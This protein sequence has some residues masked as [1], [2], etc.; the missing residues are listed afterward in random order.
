M[1]FRVCCAYFSVS[2]PR[3][4]AFNLTPSR[5]CCEHPF[6]LLCCW[7]SPI[8][9]RCRAF[10]PEHTSD[11]AG[12]RVC[13]NNSTHVSWQNNQGTTRRAAE[14]REHAMQSERK[15]EKVRFQREAAALQSRLLGTMRRLVYV[16]DELNTKNGVLKERDAYIR[17]LE[18]QLVQTH[19]RPGKS[20]SCGGGVAEP[21][22]RRRT[23][24]T[25]QQCDLSASL[26]ERGRAA[27]V[28]ASCASSLPRNDLR[29][30]A[31][32]L[33]LAGVLD[34][35]DTGAAATPAAAVARRRSSSPETPAP[36]HPAPADSPCMEV[37]APSVDATPSCV[38]RSP[39]WRGPGV[40][41]QRHTAP[42]QPVSKRAASAVRRGGPAGQQT[43]LQRLAGR[44]HT[45]TAPARRAPAVVR[46]EQLPWAEQRASVGYADLQRAARKSGATLARDCLESD[47][48]AEVLGTPAWAA[49][50]ASDC[51]TGHAVRDGVADQ[52][53][54]AMPPVGR[55][56][57]FVVAPLVSGGLQTSL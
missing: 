20:Q 16:A 53:A 2:L 43:P 55:C 14:S 25:G 52:P 1:L 42:R 12:Q 22:P 45:S 40:T 37:P 6:E 28:R 36:R 41:V 7:N 4:R 5:R 18:F 39:P 30:V 27:D 3:L 29:Q 8:W 35:V 50:E 9:P 54:G 26:P 33:G 47:S 19:R 44:R 17:R 48:R 34:S 32:R 46:S 21:S 24:D 51:S 23:V 11:T 49:E 56:L 15:A 38:G 57:N 31:A 13:R 10:V